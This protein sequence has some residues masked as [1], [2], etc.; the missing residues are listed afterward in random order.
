MQI[1][2]ALVQA[3]I[4]EQFPQ[5]A[6]LPIQPAPESGWDNRTFRIGGALS[7]RLPSAQAYES[8]AHVEHRWLPYLRPRLPLVIPEPIALGQP[9]RDYPWSWSIYR[10]IEG[11]CA[12]TS[13]AGDPGKFATDLALFL[14]ALQAI[15]AT[16]GPM[17]GRHNFHRGGSLAGYDQQFHQAV[18]ALGSQINGTAAQAVWAR[19][20]A[21]SWTSL[22]VWVHGDISL[23]NLLLQDGRLAA[24]IDFGQVCVGDPACDLAIAWTYLRKPERQRFRNHLALDAATWQ[25]GQAWALWKAVILAAGLTK[26]NAVEARPHLTINEVLAEQGR[27]DA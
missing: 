23:G 3:L 26:S 11:E 8:Q 15:P 13:P 21:T 12:S 20:L 14:R 24:V 9:S 2:T 19:A 6:A 1:T 25:R 18:S 17:P 22:P 7:A 5:W 10:W 16:G 27:T 4:A